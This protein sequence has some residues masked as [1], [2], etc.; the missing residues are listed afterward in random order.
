M[1]H[2]TDSAKLLILHEADQPLLIED[3]FIKNKP[4]I[5]ILGVIF[6]PC[7]KYKKHISKTKN[8]KIKA[9]F[10]FKQ[11]KNL[12]SKVTKQHFDSK[13]TSITYYISS[14]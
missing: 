6:N 4:K 1:T 2:F 9:A 7:L 8:K 5:Q 10:A 11:Q 12:R 3:Q 13:D 14:I